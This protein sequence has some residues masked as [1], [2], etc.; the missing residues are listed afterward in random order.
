MEGPLVR[1]LMVETGMESKVL[2]LL[3]VKL[4]LQLLLNKLLKTLFQQ[5][6]VNVEYM[7]AFL[8]SADTK[9]AYMIFRVTDTKASEAA[10]A[11]L[12]V[13]SMTQEEIIE[14][15]GERLTE[16]MHTME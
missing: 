3:K 4:L 12:G 5:A 1:C 6:K 14:A 13:R 11:N 2:Q 8:G 7:Y 16:I 9:H 15:R 10:L